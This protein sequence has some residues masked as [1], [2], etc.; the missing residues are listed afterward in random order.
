LFESVVRDAGL[1]P[2]DVRKTVATGYGRRLIAQADTT[3]T[4]ITCQVHGVRSLVP[5]VQTVIDIGGQDSKVIFLD[6][7]G[8]RDFAMNDRCAAG[9]GQFL[10]LVARRLGLSLSELG[11]HA[12]RSQRPAVIS[13]MCAVF[14]ETEIISLLALGASRED[15]VAGV[16]QAVASRVATLAGRG[17]VSPVV[18]TGGVALI[19]GMREA[20]SRVLECPLVLAPEPQLTAAHGAAI[21]A[22][23]RLSQAIS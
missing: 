16:L 5:A 19:P 15:V 1:H 18:F 8:A 21:L 2:G 13:S 20:L 3:V 6:G 17:L 11:E 10:E 23:E 4:E 9:T 22:C 14:A 12:A 7:R